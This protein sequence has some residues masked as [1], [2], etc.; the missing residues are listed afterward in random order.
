VHCLTCNFTTIA[1]EFDE[2]FVDQFMET[3][4]LILFTIS[5]SGTLI[6]ACVPIEASWNFALRAHAKCFSNNTFTAIGLFN[7]GE[8]FSESWR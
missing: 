6:F 3:A 4:F 1:G 2:F 5:C 8:S 7:S